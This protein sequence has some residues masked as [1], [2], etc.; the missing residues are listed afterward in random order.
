MNNGTVEK[1]IVEQNGTPVAAFKDE[2]IVHRG[3]DLRSYTPIT[4][5]DLEA[6]I[7]HEFYLG[8]EIKRP[9]E[10]LALEFNSA[11]SHQDPAKNIVDDKADFNSIVGFTT[12]KDNKIKNQRLLTASLGKAQEYNLFIYP[13]QKFSLRTNHDFKSITFWCKPCHIEAEIAPRRLS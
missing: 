5:H 9:Y 3:Q 6:N 12:Y 7:E 8:E 13:E 2:G 4:F 10:I 1:I 11:L